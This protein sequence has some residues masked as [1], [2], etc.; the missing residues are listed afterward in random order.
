MTAPMKFKSNTVSWHKYRPGPGVFITAAFIGPGTVT[1]CMKAGV[2]FGFDLVWLLGFALISTYVLQEMS[3]RIGIITQAG[4][5]RVLLLQPYRPLVKWSL[6]ALVLMT[7]VLGNTV[8]EGGNITGAAIGAEFL[9]LRWDQPLLSYK[10]I[11]LIV[12]LIAGTVLWSG[13]VKRL[14]SVLILAV[15]GM[16]FSFIGS[17]I[18]LGWGGMAF[19]AGWAPRLPSSSGIIAMGLIGTTIVPYNLFLHT[20]LSAQKWRTAESIPVARKDAFWSISIGILIS[21]AILSASAQS[22]VSNIQSIQ[23]MGLI[24]GSSFGDWSVYLI[25]IGIFTAGLSSALTA[26]YAAG[27]LI[28][29]SIPFSERIGISIQKYTALTILLIGTLTAYMGVKPLQLILSAQVANGILL[30]LIVGVLITLCNDKQL[31]G[32][33]TNNQWQNGAAVLIWCVT[34]L[35][36]VKALG[37][38]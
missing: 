1:T 10:I 20:S 32:R 6:I 29:E 3:M 22:G 26:P 16:S 31:L 21:I 5:G 4:L 14:Q 8:Y 36:S 25:S 35:L 24:L 27:L 19:L 13:S 37:L 33:H 9:L 2:T 12:G 17:W 18:A 23:D 7:I 28:R 34:L 15:M 30:P 11:V 38:L